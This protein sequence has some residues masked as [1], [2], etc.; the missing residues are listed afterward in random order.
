MSI[1]SQQSSNVSPDRPPAAPNLPP[2][3]SQL[4]AP[5]VM[6]QPL[7]VRLLHEHFVDKNTKIDKQAIQVLQKYFEV[8]VRETIAR[9][10]SKKK[11]Q[12]EQAGQDGGTAAD[13][14]I[15]WLEFEDLEKVAAGML[16]DF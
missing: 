15:S 1:S 12:V 2:P 3:P 11:E 9:A 4:D 6:P 13:I 8:F 16:L 14:D 7:L 5:P 10:Q